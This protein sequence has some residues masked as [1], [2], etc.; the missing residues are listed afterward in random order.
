MNSQVTA[1]VLNLNHAGIWTFSLQ[2]LS[3]SVCVCVCVCVCVLEPVAAAM[4]YHGATIDLQC[5]KEERC[6]SG[7]E[8]NWHWH[9]EKRLYLSH[10]ETLGAPYFEVSFEYISWHQHL[11]CLFIYL[12]IFLSGRAECWTSKLSGTEWK[13]LR[14][15]QAEQGEKLY[16]EYLF[17]VPYWFKAGIRN[18]FGVFLVQTNSECWIVRFVVLFCYSL[19]IKSQII[20]KFS[21]RC[22]CLKIIWGTTSFQ[23]VQYNQCYYAG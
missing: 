16:Y 18:R 12:F 15:W 13:M 22:L 23:Q 8:L 1:R 10:L 21:H 14:S 11:F 7:A 4:Q 19:F 20:K 9:F 5:L 6:T 3:Y 17:S 2:P